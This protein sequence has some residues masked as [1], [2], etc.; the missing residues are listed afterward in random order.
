MNPAGRTPV[1]KETERNIVLPDS[2]AICEYF[3]ETVDRTP[4][5]SGTAQQRAEIRRLIAMFDENFYHDVS[6]PLLLERMQKR[7]VLR[8]SQD[9]RVPREAIKLSHEYL[10]SI[11][12]MFNNPPLLAGPPTPQL[13]R[14]PY[15]G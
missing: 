12:Y 10:D 3:E 5:I 11:H 8:H 4:L 2:R 13:G 14:P 9:A 1:V 15:R 6:G 7:L